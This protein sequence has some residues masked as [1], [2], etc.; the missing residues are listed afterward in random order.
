MVSG[1]A[2][3]WLFVQIRTES[4]VLV[5]VGFFE[6]API[7]CSAPLRLPRARLR[8]STSVNPEQV[9]CAPTIAHPPN[10]PVMGILQQLSDWSDVI[11]F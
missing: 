1:F 6:R 2:F 9:K 7:L 3:R 8:K 4:P 5:T 11:F 10:G